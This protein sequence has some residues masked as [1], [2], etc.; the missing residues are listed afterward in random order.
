MRPRV[1]GLPETVTIED[2]E[3]EGACA[4]IDPG[5]VIG[6]DHN[7]ARSTLEPR[8]SDVAFVRDVVGAANG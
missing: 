4:D 3:P 1:T 2:G 6:G 8:E 7:M 5:V